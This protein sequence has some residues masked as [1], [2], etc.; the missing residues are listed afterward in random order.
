MCSG[1]S[2]AVLLTGGVKY[3]CCFLLLAVA[4]AGAPFS[5][6]WRVKS[7]AGGELW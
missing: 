7:L 6:C 3:L 5:G 4:V 1:A 2:A